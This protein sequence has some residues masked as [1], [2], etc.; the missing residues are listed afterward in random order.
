M[1]RQLV[2]KKE[3]AEANNILYEFNDVA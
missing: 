1:Q 3:D 2:Q